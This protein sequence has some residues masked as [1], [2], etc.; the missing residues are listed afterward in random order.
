M[1]ILP[2]PEVILTHESDLDGL[3]AG[4]LLQRLAQKLFG[5]KV[6]LEAF[7]YNNWK[8]R[9]LREKSAWVTDLNFE[10]RL[11]KPNWVVIDHHT[12]EA[13]AKNAHLIHDLGKSAGL[14]CY[15][16]CKEHGLG[17]P[18]L[19][20]LVHLNNVSDLFLE[21]DPDFEMA[22]DYANLVKVYQF[23]NLHSLIKGRLEDLLDHPLLEVMAVKRRVENPMGFAW[24]RDN[25]T[26]LSPTIGYV[27][28]IIGNNNLIVHQLL[29]EKA[30]PYPVLLTLFRRT[31]GV[32]IVSL[33]SRNGEALKIAEKLQGGGHANAC[34]ATLPKSV[35]NIPDALV[36][37]RETLNPKKDE[38]LN[39]LESLFDSMGR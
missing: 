39:S 2:R 4:V 9:E 7:H 18:A 8:Q 3:V 31:N 19:D 5:D 11:D 38:R 6:R 14:L 22:N 27:D 26:E 15:E 25:V 17:S 35:R 21:N 10:A 36:Y 13:P 12:T 34:G 29:E 23:W 1:S 16:L 24:S 32:V 37:L 20:R 33:R 30:T 28:T